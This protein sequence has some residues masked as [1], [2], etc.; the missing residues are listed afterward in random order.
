[1]VRSWINRAKANAVGT[2]PSADTA[3]AYG[4]FDICPAGRK[5]K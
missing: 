4:T 1:M 5:S 3:F 2:G